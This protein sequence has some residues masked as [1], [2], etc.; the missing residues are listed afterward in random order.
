MIYLIDDTNLESV[1]G[2][3]VLDERFHEVLTLI[4][5]VATLDGN[6]Q[7][8]PQADC[9]MIHR[10]FAQSSV[11]KE[12]IAE[13]TDDGDKIPLVIFSAGDSEHAVYSD[14][15]P[16]VIEGIKKSVFYSR[17]SYFL[18]T[19]LADHTIDLRLLAYGKDYTK[20]RV[21]GLAL[22][23]LRLTAGCQGPM[24]V[25]DLAAVATPQLKELI[26][27]SNPELGIDYDTLLEQ[28]EDAPLTFEQFRIN[29]NKIV[30]SFN[31]YGKNIY[32][33]K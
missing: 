21:R 27:L 19:Y 15:R 30:N 32:P 33:W 8:L 5:D 4:H 16:N 28:L 26:E 13:L 14:Q 23:V 31:Q 3:F 2:T 7:A 22:T 20:I 24:S 11:F 1:S 12:Q 29:I 18:N 10:T 17:L 25:A 9:I 6:R